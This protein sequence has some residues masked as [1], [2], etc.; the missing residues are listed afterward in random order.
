MLQ[1]RQFLAASAGCLLA[2]QFARAAQTS[3]KKIAFIGTEVRTHS[4]AQH[5]LDRLTAGY[6]WA[7]G[8]VAPRVE[9]AGGYSEQFPAGDLARERHAKPL[10]EFELIHASLQPCRK[11]NKAFYPNRQR[12]RQARKADAPSSRG[13]PS[14]RAFPALMESKPG[15]SFLF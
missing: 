7:G 9:V 10:E 12:L 8:W 15:S 13:A 6:A 1:R 11:W 3:R 14:A 2:T 4:H 5:F